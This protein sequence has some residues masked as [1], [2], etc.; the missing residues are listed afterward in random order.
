VSVVVSDAT[1]LNYL[2]LIEAIDLLPRLFSRVLIP[3]AV[4][5]ELRSESAPPE[6]LRWICEAPCWLDTLRPQRVDPSLGLDLGETEAISLA[7]E[8]SIKPILIDERKGRRIAAERG[9]VIVGTLAVLERA[10]H[11]GWIDFSEYVK[12]LRGTT[13]RFSEELVN[14]ALARLRVSNG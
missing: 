13:F 7:L 5:A 1:P 10:A 9:L 4:E 11:K 3:P 14:Q 12:R 2:V 8:L 6:V